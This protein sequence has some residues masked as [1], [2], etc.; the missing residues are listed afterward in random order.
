MADVSAG[1]FATKPTRWRIATGLLLALAGGIVFMIT[2]PPGR[3]GPALPLTVIIPEGVIEPT[4]EP[5]CREFT[6]VDGIRTVGVFHGGFRNTSEEILSTTT[7]FQARSDD[8]IW[9]S[10]E[11]ALSDPGMSA[12]GKIYMF[13]PDGHPE[14]QAVTER[15]IGCSVR[16]QARGP[17]AR[18]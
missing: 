15:I 14:V 11:E 7:T 17:N 10:R 8:Q 9:S 3:F 18:V 4:G 6:T 13:E 12:T 1:T 16:I 5:V 2:R